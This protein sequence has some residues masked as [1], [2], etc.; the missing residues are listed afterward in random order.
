MKGTWGRLCG[1][2]N[3]ELGGA[4]E[5]ES[6]TTWRGWGRKKKRLVWGLATQP[7]I[8]KVCHC[9]G[10]E[11]GEAG[12]NLPSNHPNNIHVDQNTCISVRW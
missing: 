10:E 12:R 3:E 8:W 5:E 4:L 11:E 6:G 7:M 9:W 2:G 1:E